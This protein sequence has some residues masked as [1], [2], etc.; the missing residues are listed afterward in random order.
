[1]QNK[2]KDFLMNTHGN[3]Y[4]WKNPYLEGIPLVGCTTFF[5]TALSHIIT[6]EALHNICCENDSCSE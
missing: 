5:P 2:L 1:M 4:Y 3:L 6:F